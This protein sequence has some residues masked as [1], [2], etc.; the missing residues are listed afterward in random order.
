L[1]NERVCLASAR[2]IMLCKWVIILNYNVADHCVRHLE[3]LGELPD[4]GMFFVDNCSRKEDY[5]RLR[6][7]CVERG[8]CII[9]EH[10][11]STAG[12]RAPACLEAGAK[13][14]LIRNST[15]LGYSAGN[16]TAM[17]QLDPLLGEHGDY[18]IINPDVY[19]TP[20]TAT[21][22]LNA[23]A[24]LCGPAI[25]EHWRRGIATEGLTIDFTTGFEPSGTP[26]SRRVSML[27]GSCLKLTGR[28]LRKYGFLPD[29]NF[30]YEEEIRYFERV[31]RLGGNPVYLD[32][33]QV[34]HIG[35]ASTKPL[36]YN[37]FYYIFRNRLAYFIE[38]AGPEYKRHGRFFILYCG[39]VQDVLRSQARK[40]NWAG[41]RGMTLGIWHGLRGIKGPLRQR[42]SS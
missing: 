19:I 42:Q 14:V 39:W 34:E 1:A 20:F 21:A 22:L 3:T 10:P 12:T 11:G 28:A 2:L 29:D 18:L 32:Q 24:E 40:R 30:L 17:R 26:D 27:H 38:V 13:L 5:E 37:Y 23:E 31:H 33:L 6:K 8:A 25:Y 35:K 4:I 16:N 15:N 7:A 36:S 41:I 9:E